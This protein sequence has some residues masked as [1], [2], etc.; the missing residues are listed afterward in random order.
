VGQRLRA[1]RRS[2]SGFTLTEL[3]IV[4]VILGVLTGIVVFAVNAF[5]DEGDVAACRSDE[6]TV[7]TAV[8]S[9]RA[10]SA[11]FVYPATLAA[12][13]PDYIR[14]V[15]ADDAGDP[16]PYYLQY[17]VATGLVEGK[18]DDGTDC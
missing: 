1:N 16:G 18:L 14:D 15:P 12:L 13:R 7:Q 4:I 6:R 17:T 10:Q 11:T 2:D 3:L 5:S 8:E 9:Y